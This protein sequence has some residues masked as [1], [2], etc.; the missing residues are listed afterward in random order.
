MSGDEIVVTGNLPAD[1]PTVWRLI[2]QPGWFISDEHGDKTGQQVTSDERGDILV[3]PRFGS[4]LFE[5]LESDAPSH[6][7][8]RSSF[9]AKGDADIDFDAG[10]STVISF[11]LAEAEGGSE[12]T[13]RESGFAQLAS[14]D[15][16]LRAMQDQNGEG[17]NIGLRSLQR[18]IAADV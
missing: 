8:I 17:W 7:T 12:L 6:L 18:M 1:R 16:Q 10:A 15:E 13:V 11:D 3:D 4:F 14:D 9:L 5:T 2:S